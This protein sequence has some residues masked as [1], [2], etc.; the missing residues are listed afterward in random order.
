MMSKQLENATNLYLRGIRDGQIKEVHDHYMGDSYTQHSTGVPDEKEGF[1]AFFVDF[2]KRNPKREITIVR[3]FED[4]PFVFVHVHQKL[5]DGEAEWVTSDIFRSDDEC[6]IV[7]HWDVID[8]YP[9]EIGEID[10]IYGEVSLTDFDRTEENKKI[11]RRF[12]VDVLQ[13]KE[14]DQFE[15][16]VSDD[17]IQHNQEIAQ[18]GPSFKQ[19]LLENDASVDFVFK[20]IGQ[21]NLVVAYSKMWIAH[22]DYAIMQL[23]RLEDGKIV[24]HWDNKEVMPKKSELTNLGKF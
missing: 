20:V 15:K 18:G 23:F 6:R 12:F 16:Y 4:G 7:E 8:A 22:Q 3:S 9:K 11:V 14:W 1:E 10:P 13:N 21:G 19:Y 24:E 5:N 2:F 17:L